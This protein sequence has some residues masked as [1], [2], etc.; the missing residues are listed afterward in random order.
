MSES[1]V[2]HA[3]P[4]A[5]RKRDAAACLGMSEDSFERY[6]QWDVRVVRRGKITLYPVAE[7][8]RWVERHA[9]GLPE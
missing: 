7:L 4:I 6:V 5:L 1:P 3:Q 2:F 9:E 8:Q